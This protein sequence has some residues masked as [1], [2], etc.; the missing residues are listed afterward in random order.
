VSGRLIVTRVSP[1]SPADIAG[2]KSGDIIL[3]VGTEA[4]RSQADFYKKV[5]S[6]RRAGDTV[7]LRVLQ[8]TDIKELKVES[9]DRTQYFRPATTY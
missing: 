1:D 2:M 3:G 9:I 8:G 7:P 4:V 5:W 6:K